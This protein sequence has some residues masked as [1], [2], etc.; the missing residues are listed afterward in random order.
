VKDLIWETKHEDIPNYIKHW[1]EDVN[2]Y[3]AIMEA[4]QDLLNNEVE[5]IAFFCGDYENEI[6]QYFTFMKSDKM[7][8]IRF[9]DG[10]KRLAEYEGSSLHETFSHGLSN[11]IAIIAYAV[12]F[13]TASAHANKHGRKQVYR[14]KI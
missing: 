11:H 1:Q 10:Y 5:Y 14:L 2:G 8:R 7:D 4:F 6:G 13:L 3:R 9:Y 12:E